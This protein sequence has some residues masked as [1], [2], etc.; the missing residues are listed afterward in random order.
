M[1]QHNLIY[2]DMSLTI[3]RVLY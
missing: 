1:L 3:S 2:K